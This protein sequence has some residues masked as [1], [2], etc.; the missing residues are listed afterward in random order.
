M[1]TCIAHPYIDIITTDRAFSWF[2][3]LC[4]HE[5]IDYITGGIQELYQR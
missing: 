1:S 4:W 3:R 5:R 2:E